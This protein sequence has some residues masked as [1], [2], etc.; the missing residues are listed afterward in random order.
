MK[1]PGVKSPFTSEKR[2]SGAALLSEGPEDP[3]SLC[4]QCRLVLEKKVLRRV[5]K[6]F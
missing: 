6:T 2:E 1:T 5:G 4:M 3:P